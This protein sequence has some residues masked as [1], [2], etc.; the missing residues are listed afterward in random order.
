MMRA[1]DGVPAALWM[2]DADARCTFVNRAWREFTG[3]SLAESLGTGWTEAIHPED[4]ARLDR[5]FEQY[6]RRL[7]FEME[8]RMRRADGEHRW[9]HAAGRPQFG[10]DGAFVGFIACWTDVSERKRAEADLQAAESRFRLAAENAND[11]IYEW[12]LA[13]GAIAFFGCLE[14]HMGCIRAE[15]PGDAGCFSRWLHPDDRGRVLAAR[16]RSLQT[17]D[18]FGQEYR[19]LRPGGGVSYWVERGA[20]LRDAAGEPYRWIGVATD[21]TERRHADAELL[22]LAAFVDSSDD[23]FAAYD[24]DGAIVSWNRGAELLYG[25]TA[26]EALGQSISMLVPPERAQELAETPGAGIKNL[27]TVRLRKDKS[28]TAVLLTLT[29][30]P[31]GICEVARCLDS[32]YRPADIQQV[33]SLEAEPPEPAPAGAAPEWI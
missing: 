18:A 32:A 3:M 14:R 19:L 9:M 7:E 17:G 30:L 2:G 25:Y 27:E 8:L 20:A 1:L 5:M 13:T 21:I 16:A 6:A 28:R 23:A 26:A 4:R 24:M 22:R 33:R 31:I 15:L 10:S 29:P 12:D 11:V